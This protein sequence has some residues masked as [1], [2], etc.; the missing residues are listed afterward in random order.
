[1]N[2]KNMIVD[3]IKI[4]DHRVIEIVDTFIGRFIKL[5]YRVPK[6]FLCWHY[7]KLVKVSDVYVGYYGI[8]NAYNRLMFEDEKRICNKRRNKKRKFEE[9]LFLKKIKTRNE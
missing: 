1:M 3:K 2:F 9:N 8:E 5:Y 6:K 4:D 7:I